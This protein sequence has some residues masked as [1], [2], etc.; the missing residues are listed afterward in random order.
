M[1]VGYLLFLKMFQPR[2]IK[3]FRNSLM[4]KK[5][6]NAD[7]PEYKNSVLRKIS[8]FDVFGQNGHFGQFWAFWAIFCYVPLMF[9]GISG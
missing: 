3:A 6:E 8:D 5:G 2:E 4:L 9:D 7:Y 1:F